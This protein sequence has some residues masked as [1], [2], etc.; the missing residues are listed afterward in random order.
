[1]LSFLLSYIIQSMFTHS[2]GQQYLFSSIHFTHKQPQSLPRRRTGSSSSSSITSRRHRRHRRRRRVLPYPGVVQG[3][4]EPH[5]LA[6]V[7]VKESCD[8]LLGVR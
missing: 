7:A 4:P 8:K 1:M 6:R 3:V 2:Y 5:A